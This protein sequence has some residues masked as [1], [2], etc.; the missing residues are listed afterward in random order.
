M[1]TDKF[2]KSGIQAHAEEYSFNI[3]S[4]LFYQLTKEQ[5]KLWRKEIEQAYISGGEIGVELAKDPRYKENLEVKEVDLCEEEE[6]IWKDF[7]IGECHL[8]K[9]DLEKI[10]KHFF[11]LGL[12]A[13]RKSISIQNVDDVLKES[14]V[15]PDSKGAKMFKESYYAAIDKLLEQKREKV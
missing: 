6:R 14:G 10:A 11:E 13:Q 2:L 9:N 8:S 4:E 3:E 1:N 15:D 7:N 12:K 5:Q